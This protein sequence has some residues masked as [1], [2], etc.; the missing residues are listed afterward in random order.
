MASKSIFQKFNDDAIAHF[1]ISC[2]PY[3]VMTSATNGTIET[4]YLDESDGIYNKIEDILESSKT[5]N[6]SSYK[7]A[8]L[9]P[10][11]RVSADRVKSALKEHGVVL[12]SDYMKA[13]IYITHDF[14]ATSSENSENI[15][16]RF[17]LNHL[18]NY[19][20][21]ESGCNTIDTYCEENARGGNLARVVYDPKCE[22]WVS[23]YNTD[24]Y[25]MPYDAWMMT[26]MAVNIAHRI[27]T[28]EATTMDVESV[29][30]SSA[31][32]VE[33]TEELIEQIVTMLSSYDDENIEMAGKILPTI[34]YTKKKHL[35][36]KLGQEIGSNI[37]RISRN[38]D[39]DYWKKISNVEDYYHKSAL[40]MIK[41]LEDRDQ[42]DKTAFKY[43]EPIVRKEIRIDNR[44][45]YVFKVEVKP[46]YKKYL[47]YEENN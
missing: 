41:F 30:H 16:T 40:D 29:L 26:G 1:G 37:Y 5:T 38:K 19:E 10:N 8:Y 6:L 14:I 9:L 35:M 13:E 33:I 4:V 17:L 15:S 3:G 46:E 18:W 2:D 7:K 25:A 44:D 47:K 43:L 23:R 24:F 31:N 34:D 12:T 28:G 36:W 27:D 22:G 20:A 21:V 39:V 45:L 42:L 11:C 32:K